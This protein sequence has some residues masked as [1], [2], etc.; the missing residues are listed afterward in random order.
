MINS[1]LGSQLLGFPTNPPILD[2][3]RLNS[4]IYLRGASCPALSMRMA[5]MQ[6]FTWLWGN[7]QLSDVT[8]LLATKG[9]RDL[10]RDAVD[11]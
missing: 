4:S 6:Q 3:P 8:L 10:K 2:N 9:E 1:S 5:A 11:G 7:A